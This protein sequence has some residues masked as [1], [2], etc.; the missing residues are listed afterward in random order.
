MV[1]SEL[2]PGLSG[3]LFLDGVRGFAGVRHGQLRGEEDQ[4]EHQPVGGVQ[5]EGD[6]YQDGDG[7]TEQWRL[8]G[9]GRINYR[10]RVGNLG[11]FGNVEGKKVIN[12]FRY[13][14][15]I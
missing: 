11:R 15:E 7:E 6:G 12:I 14:R 3:V 1:L 8:P 10:P 4:A 5:Q 13:I 2:C 9:P